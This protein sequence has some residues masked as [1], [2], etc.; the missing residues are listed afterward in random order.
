MQFALASL[1]MARNK[2][3]A[4]DLAKGQKSNATT[5][6]TGLIG[7]VGGWLV[8]TTYV[9]RY[10]VVGQLGSGNSHLGFWHLT[11]STFSA[12]IE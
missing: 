9:R 6:L 10:E 4:P 12:S 8:S 2:R 7:S 11:V 3:S 1:P 5:W